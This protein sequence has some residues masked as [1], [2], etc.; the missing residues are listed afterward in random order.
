[1]FKNKLFLTI[2]IIGAILGLSY[3]IPLLGPFRHVFGSLFKLMWWALGLGLFIGGFIDYYV[4]REYVSQILAQPKKRTI[5]YSVF[6][7]FLMAV[8]NHGVLAIAIQFYKK[9]ASTSSVVAFLLASP[10]ANFP[11]TL[12]MIGFFGLMKGLFLIFTA[13]LIAIIVGL[14]YQAFERN[15][16]V[17]KN[18]YVPPHDA[19]FDLRKD[20]FARMAAYRFTPEQLMADAKGVVK[21]IKDLSNMTLWWLLIGLT[22][23]SFAAAYIPEHFF[24]HYMG[25]SFGGMTFTL[26]AAT[27]METC[28]TG[29]SP[30][31][32]EI[33]RQTGALGNALV[34]LMAGVATNYTAIG[35]LW[36]NAGRRTA[37]WLPVVS[38]PLVLFFGFLANKLF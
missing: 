34:F 14:I 25:K 37:L 1:M 38:V 13:I 3:F 9:G 20:I 36:V 7:G 18:P 31:A 10:W 4:P 28:S 29:M 5:F 35:L 16:V 15:G 30:L 23:A 21:G 22:L 33:Y 19:A 2:L 6:L 17:E 12:M 26:V 32:F 24:H 8:C 11:L 27:F